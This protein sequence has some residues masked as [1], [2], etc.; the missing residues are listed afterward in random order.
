MMKWL[1]VLLILTASTAIGF[2]VAADYRKRPRLIQGILQSLR[3]LRQE[4]EYSIQPLPQALKSVA[5]RA[6]SPC[7]EWFRVAAEALLTSDVSVESAFHQ[8]VD[9]HRDID[10]L[11]EGDYD[12]MLHL[13]EVIAITNRSHLTLQFDTAIL[14]YEGILAVAEDKRKKN[15]KLWQYFGALGGLLII[16]ILI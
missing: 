16:V 15:E 9:A 1:G 14:Q 5:M 6:P 8:G 12:V 13:A 3:L 7:N 4:I 10:A 11:A 2:R